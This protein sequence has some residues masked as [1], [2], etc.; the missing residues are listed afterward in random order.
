ME[1]FKISLKLGYEV[2]DG[3]FGMHL[4]LMQIVESFVP[5]FVGGRSIEFL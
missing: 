5:V 1:S 3:V 4:E 2:G